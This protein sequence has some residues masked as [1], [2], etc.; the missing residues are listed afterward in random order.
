MTTDTAKKS[1]FGKMI[2]NHKMLL[3]TMFSSRDENNELVENRFIKWAVGDSKSDTILEI[4][5]DGKFSE[6]YS[7][8]DQVNNYGISSLVEATSGTVKIVGG[9]LKIAS[10]ALEVVIGG[11][12]SFSKFGKEL[13]ENGTTSV[14]NGFVL[15]VVGANDLISSPISLVTIPSGALYNKAMGEDLEDVI[16]IKHRPP[17]NLNEGFED[18][19]NLKDNQV[20]R[21]KISIKPKSEAKSSDSSAS[22]IPVKK[23]EERPNPST[24]T[25]GVSFKVAAD[26]TKQAKI[27]DR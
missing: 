23:D 1:S 22:V 12:T 13:L 6:E 18:L 11:L 8:R 16:R 14:G 3:R 15:L 7:L 24:K 5:R 17:F 19:E 21:D 9:S 27:Q 4:A 20:L 25:V 2:H 10:G 26:T